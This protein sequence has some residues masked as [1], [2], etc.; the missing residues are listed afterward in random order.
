MT[1]TSWGWAGSS[2]TQAGTETYLMFLLTYFHISFLASLLTFF[3]S[4]F[5]SL[6]AYLPPCF[7]AWLFISYSLTSSLAY[8]L[9]CLSL[10]R[11][12]ANWLIAYLLTYLRAYLLTCLLAYNQYKI[13]FKTSHQH[14][15]I[16][17]LLKFSCLNTTSL[18][19]SSKTRDW[20]KPFQA[21][22]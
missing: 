9:A 3:I 8:L 22:H 15:T 14:D 2:S 21:E 1:K 19:F 10:T 18:R 6:L 4:L 16:E 5:S 7:L 17:N 11:L 13:H 12:L 20:A